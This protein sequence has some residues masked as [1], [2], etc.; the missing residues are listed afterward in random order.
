MLITNQRISC[1]LVLAIF[2][3][4][5]LSSNTLAQTSQTIKQKSF[6]LNQEN[7]LIQQSDRLKI[8]LSDY[9]PNANNLN[10]DNLPD[11][12]QAEQIKITGNSVFSSSEL[13]A[14]IKERD[15]QI[16]S[17]NDLRQ[18]IQ[19]IN[20]AYRDRGYVT[21]GVFS[22]PKLEH[23]GKIIIPVTEGKIADVNI[24]GLK[25]LRTNYVHN[26]IVRD[27]QQVLNQEQ[28][29]QALQLLEVNHL[30]KTVST[31]VILLILI[32]TVVMP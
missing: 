32:L 7:Y 16:V 31:K 18:I 26:R 10:L 21:S 2:K 20:Q 24:T 27:P 25:R 8:N 23:T 1:C 13:L 9:A 5:L 11:S 14:L 17:K 22:K 4:L 29:N 12:I 3:T 30:I 15:K 19:Q 28:L 6:D